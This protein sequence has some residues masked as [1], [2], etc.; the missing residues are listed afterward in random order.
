MDNEGKK[1]KDTR[2]RFMG[3]SLFIETD[4]DRDVLQFISWCQ[5]L[6]PLKTHEE[7]KQEVHNRLNG[8]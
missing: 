6:S 1:L 5:R 2:M 7:Y 8:S 3:K 4:D